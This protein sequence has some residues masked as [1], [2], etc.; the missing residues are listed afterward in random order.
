MASVPAEDMRAML[1][2]C[3]DDRGPYECSLSVLPLSTADS[4][5]RRNRLV[6]PFGWGFIV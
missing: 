1:M 3:R 5:G 2:R 4:T 6:K